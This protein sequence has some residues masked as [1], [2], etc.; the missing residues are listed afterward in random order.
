MKV[1]FM[2]KLKIKGEKMIKLI[3]FEGLDGSGKT[4]LINSL[5][6]HL[7]NP[8]QL[9][10]GLGS[11]SL[12]KE[13]RGLFLNFQQVDYLTRF[14]LSLANMAQIQ[15]EL[16]VSQLKNNQLII[17][18]RWLPSTYAYQ[19]FPFSKE[20]KQLLLLKKIFKLNHETILKNPIY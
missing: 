18:D 17:L 1:F 4:S 5:Q 9:Y 7:K 10:Q 16:I 13:I 3:V 14:Y 11:S 12:G 19:L 15:A 2:P 6:P 8:Y 20:K